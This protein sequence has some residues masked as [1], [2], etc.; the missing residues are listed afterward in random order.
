MLRGW[1]IRKDRNALQ[2]FRADISRRQG[3][4]RVVAEVVLLLGMRKRILERFFE[5]PAETLEWGVVSSR[6][7]VVAV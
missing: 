3:I 1:P 4:E 7:R 2:H 6:A 5:L